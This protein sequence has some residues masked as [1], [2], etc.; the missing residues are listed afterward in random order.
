MYLDV[1]SH[2]TDGAGFLIVTLASGLVAALPAIAANPG[3]TVSLLAQNLPDASNFFLTCE[4]SPKYSLAVLRHL[5]RL[6]HYR[7]IRRCGIF[8]ADLYLNPM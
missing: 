5:R 3:S 1:R 4:L 2:L 8:L 6:R 7:S